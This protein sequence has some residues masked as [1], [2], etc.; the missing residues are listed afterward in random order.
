M[1]KYFCDLWQHSLWCGC[2][3]CDLSPPSVVTKQVVPQYH[4]NLSSVNVTLSTSLCQRHLCCLHLLKKVLQKHLF[5]NAYL[6]LF[7]STTQ[8]PSHEVTA[9]KVLATFKANNNMKHVLEE[10]ANQ[11]KAPHFGS[12]Y[13]TQ[14]LEAFIPAT[15]LGPATQWLFSVH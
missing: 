8:N 5:Q 6:P 12:C 13:R 10:K 11:Q 14:G 9:I 7:H 15:S 1:Y 3:L 2:V 4:A